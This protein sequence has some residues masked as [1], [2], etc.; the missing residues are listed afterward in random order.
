MPHCSSSSHPRLQCLCPTHGL[1]D[2]MGFTGTSRALLRFERKGP[3]LSSLSS[4]L[5]KIRWDVA[6]CFKDSRDVWLVAACKHAHCY[7]ARTRG[8]KSGLC[9]CTIQKERG[10]H[11]DTY[12]M[13]LQGASVAGPAAFI[14]M[15]QQLVNGSFLVSGGPTPLP[16]PAGI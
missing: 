3:L 7:Y 6:R 10:R 16:M 1:G 9:S 15:N 13:W 4:S 8:S 12:H 14:P 2:F 5:L 11:L